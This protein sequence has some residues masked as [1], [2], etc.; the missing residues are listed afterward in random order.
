M[1]RLLDA[2][3]SEPL[4]LMDGAM[5]S[6]LYQAG[7]ES[8]ECG[9]EWNLSRPERVHA[10]HISYVQAGARV[11]LTNTFQANPCNLVRHGL[12]DQ[13]ER[14][15][16]AGV[17]LARTAAG[18][19][20][21]VL[22]DIGPILYSFQDQDISEWDDLVRTAAA[23]S[24]PD[25]GWHGIDGILLETC[26]SP[27]SLSAVEVLRHRVLDH[28][29]VPVLLSLTYRRQGREVRTHSGHAPETFAR[30]AARHGVAALG[31]NCGRE[32]GI[33]DMVE[34]LRRYRRETDLPLFARP[35]AGTPSDRSGRLLYPHTA[36]AMATKVRSLMDAG[37]TMIG[38]CCGTTPAYIA[39]F[40]AAI[41][42]SPKGP[43]S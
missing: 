37:A 7:L 4:L 42:G 43:L 28:A 5:G 39:A 12:E 25:L 27:R 33:D 8:G 31:V 36:E 23:F 13:L 24:G 17:R 22:G 41:L 1:S 20:G 18:P 19:D 30:H 35:N 15:I 16:A 21:F 29:D 40:R 6:E 3:R 10:I 14:I 9:E 32:I 38:G 34:V 2:L 26:S 11:L